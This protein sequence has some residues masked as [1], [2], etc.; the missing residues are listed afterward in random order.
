ME[1]IE[2]QIK[3]MPNYVPNQT[4]LDDKYQTCKN[5]ECDSGDEQYVGALQQDMGT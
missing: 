2:R 4:S 1:T 5:E 3:K